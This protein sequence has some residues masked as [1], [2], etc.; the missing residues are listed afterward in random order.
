MRYAL[1]LL[2]IFLALGANAQNVVVTGRPSGGAT[3]TAPGISSSDGNALTLTGPL[4]L[5]NLSGVLQCLQANAS[6]VVTGT[7]SACGAGGGGGFAGTITYTS[8]QTGSSSDNQKLVLMNCSSA[9]AY[10]LPGTQPSATWQ[11]YV[12]TIGS[13]N[14]TIVLGGGDTFNGTTSVPTPIKWQPLFVAANSATTTD[15]EGQ[16][17]LIAGTSLTLTPAANGLTV[18]STASGTGSC[19]NQVVTALNSGSSPTCT[20]ATSAYVDS[21]VVTDAGNT[22]TTANKV[23][24]STTTAGKANVADFPDTKVIP[25]A[26]C[27]NTTAG[28]GWSIGSGGTATCRAGT[29]NKGGYI[30][31]TDTSSTFAQFVIEIPEDW[32]SSAN[33]YIRVQV[34]STDTT[35][36]HTIIPQIQVSC[37]KGDGSTTDDV[38]FNASHSLSTITLNTTANQFWSSSNVQMNSTDMTGCVAGALMIIQ[39]GRATDTATNAEFYSATVTIPRLI[40]VQAN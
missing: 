24:V 20:T 27:N 6:N 28:T 29:N 33:P 19:T 26:N 31:I 11:A 18:A 10:T 16:A 1:A 30:S 23:L 14:A 9:C 2:T 36:G 25:A 15:Y 38:S 5:N 40:T 34:A 3:V 4:T 32:D 22:T 7:G 17:Q 35:N 13:T 39:V 8:S 37:A 12:M 21:S